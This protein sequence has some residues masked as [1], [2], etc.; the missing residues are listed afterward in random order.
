MSLKVEKL[1]PGL[2]SDGWSWL[3]APWALDLVCVMLSSMSLLSWEGT[4]WWPR[5]EMGNRRGI[6]YMVV[7]HPTWV[8]SLLLR[9]PQSWWGPRVVGKRQAWLGGTSGPN[10]CTGGSHPVNC[11]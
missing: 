9:E 11:R 1:P 6:G 4:R 5:L 10:L 7:N 8:C 2:S 3:T